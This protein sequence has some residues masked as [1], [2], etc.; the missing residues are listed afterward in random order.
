MRGSPD[1]AVEPVRH[2]Q[3][4]L[5]LAAWRERATFCFLCVFY[6]VL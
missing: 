2:R 5:D 3:E 1:G 6:F 4:T